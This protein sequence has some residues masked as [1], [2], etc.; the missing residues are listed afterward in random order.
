M[1]DCE[2][3]P[4]VSDV[5]DVPV[6]PAAEFAAAV[7]EEAAELALEAALLALVG[8]KWQDVTAQDYERVLKELKLRPRVLELTPA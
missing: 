8:K 4:T 1:S 2:P 6:S 5:V 7:A 3:V